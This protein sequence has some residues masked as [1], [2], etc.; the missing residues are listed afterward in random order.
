M[1]NVLYVLYNAKNVLSQV[2]LYNVA[3][4]LQDIMQIQLGQE[5]VVN[6]M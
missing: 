5:Y 1:T 6:V 2:Q 3:Y 4:V